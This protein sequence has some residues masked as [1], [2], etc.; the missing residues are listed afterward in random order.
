M[1]LLKALRQISAD[2][3]LS[4]EV[5][6]ERL[7]KIGCNT[8]DMD[9]G[10][11][12]QIENDIYT[13]I[14]ASPIDSIPVGT[15]VPLGDTYCAHTLNAD[16]IIAS[17]HVKHSELGNHPCYQKFG[18]ESYIGISVFVDH[19]N[20]GTLNFSST[21][22][23]S[24][25]F[26]ES[27]YEYMILLAEWVGLEI[28]RQGSLVKV[29][30]QQDEAQ[31]QWLQ[32]DQMSELAGLGTWEIDVGNGTVTWSN[33]LKRMH[34]LDESFVP[35]L[36]NVFQF[37]RFEED[38]IKISHLFKEAMKK[39]ESFSYE[40][41]IQTA[42][43]RS[44]WIRA[45]AQPVMENGKCLFV[46]G[47]SL[48]ITNQIQ[49]LEELRTQRFEAEKALEARSRFIANISHE[50]RTPLNGVTGMLGVLKKTPLSTQQERIIDTI[51]QSANNLLHIINDVLDFSKIDAGEMILEHLP[52]NVNNLLNQLQKVF[53]RSAEKKGLEFIVDISATED[54]TVLSDP[55]RL[56]QV[57]NNLISNAIKF[58]SHG[59][60]RLVTRSLQQT[61]GH[62]LINIQVEDSGIGIDEEQLEFIFSPFT[63]ADVDTTR[64]FGGTGLGLSIVAQIVELMG[65]S[66]KVTSK[67]GQGAQFTVNL[68]LELEQNEKVFIPKKDANNNT[69]LTVSLASMR[70]LVV[71]DNQIN[72]VVIEAQLSGF[73]ITPEIVDNGEIAL[74]LLKR[75]APQL[76]FDVILMDCQMPV[77]DGYT[78]TRKIRELGEKFK[79]IPIIALTANALVEERTRCL[80]SGMTDFL[81]KPVS[82]EQLES[83]LLKVMTSKDI[84]RTSHLIA[85]ES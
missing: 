38:K 55:T 30:T 72:Q 22:P 42:I 1:Q 29:L 25:E 73:G 36:A 85:P 35:T 7:L 2:T 69:E 70:V 21:K 5:K 26:T 71:E 40:I 79:C 56:L 83:S 77:M 64:K 51:D 84:D 10:I 12:S 53:S 45:Q 23:R 50:I 37:P 11:V 13:I 27:D 62:I 43:G 19:K 39:G 9:I 15:K 58:T 17:H 6:L 75:Q 44:R 4:F 18:L 60:V 57:L 65:G 52:V 80:E 61:R 32:R 31:R 54:V 74:T 34:D 20:Q 59:Q 78:A 82:I 68:S 24:Q 3:Q 63:Q 16:G 67:L 66:I 14:S 47:A 41:A 48:D 33:A 46:L 8:L 81:T 76:D 28:S 49:M